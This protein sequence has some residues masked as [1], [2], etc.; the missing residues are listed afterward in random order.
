MI[1]ERLQIGMRI[2]RLGPCRGLH[3]RLRRRLGRELIAGNDVNADIAGAAHQ[4]VHD[5]AAHDLEP[6]RA[7]RFADDDLGDVVALREVDDVVGDAAAD[8]GNGQRFAAERF[9]KP[10][11]IGEPVALLV[12]KLEADRRVSI[13]IAV[14]GACSRSASRLV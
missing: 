8:A 11:R 5:R 6:A 12:R 14:H 2:E 13:E 3:R 10:Q 9:G 4:I 1:A 7:R